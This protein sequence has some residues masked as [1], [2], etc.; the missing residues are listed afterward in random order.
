MCKLIVKLL[1]GNVIF[2]FEDLIFT[3]YKT[4]YYTSL[5]YENYNINIENRNG[6]GLTPANH[7][8]SNPYMCMVI[9]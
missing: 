5:M 2:Y 1:K 7:V 8:V 3:E 9:K 4:K 6:T